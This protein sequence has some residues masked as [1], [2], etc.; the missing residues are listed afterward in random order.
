MDLV[1]TILT[2]IARS[3]E[4]YGRRKIVAM[5][6]GDVEDLP[7]ALARVSTSGALRGERPRTVERWVDA[8]CGAGLI[9]VSDD[10]YRTLSLTALGRDVMVGRAEDVRMAP[11]VLPAARG[12]RRAQPR[13]RS[14]GT[15]VGEPVLRVQA[16]RSQA[17][18]PHDSPGRRSVSSAGVGDALRAWRTEQARRRG[19]PPYVI[20]HDRTLEAIA[21]SL[22]R[23]R[24]EL[25]GLPGIGPAKLDAHGDAIL[26]L[27]AAVRARTE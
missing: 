12:W 10:Q 6:V 26:G 21:S 8:A 18:H 3:G 24:D 22:P 5:L 19:V 2:G 23:S 13:G 4:R 16:S 17:V 27:I 25:R 20:L 11:P 15:H 9:R 14:A 7:D 1:K